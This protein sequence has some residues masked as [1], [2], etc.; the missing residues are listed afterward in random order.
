MQPEIFM[1][2]GK[3]RKRIQHSK[4]DKGSV[5][6]LSEMQKIVLRKCFNGSFIYNWRRKEKRK[7][8]DLEQSLKPSPIPL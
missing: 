2:A 6:I 1:Y 3:R 8:R 7:L 4:N 5:K